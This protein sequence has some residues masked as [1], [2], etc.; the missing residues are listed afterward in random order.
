MVGD[1]QHTDFLGLTK[2]EVFAAVIAMGIYAGPSGRVMLDSTDDS[3]LELAAET[4]FRQ[5]AILAAHG[6]RVLAS[7]GS[8]P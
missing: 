6:A 4:A 1:A 3:M 2:I 8:Q 5:G 7:M